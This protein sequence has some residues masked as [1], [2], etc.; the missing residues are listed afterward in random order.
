[1]WN[2]RLAVVARLVFG[3]M[4]ATVSVFSVGGGVVT[5][6]DLQCILLVVFDVFPL[7]N[8]RFV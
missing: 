4:R 8:G 3:Q 6:D 5:T 7:P 1:V 2:K